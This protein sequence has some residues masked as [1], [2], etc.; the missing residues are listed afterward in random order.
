[1]AVAADKGVTM[2]I[3]APNGLPT[4][5]RHLLEVLRRGDTRI[6]TSFKRTLSRA[7]EASSLGSS[8]NTLRVEELE[9]LAGLAEGFGKSPRGPTGRRRALEPTLR[10]LLARVL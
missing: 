8:V 2:A 7:L 6:Q 1:M 10:Y 3:A 9:A 5:A 4:P